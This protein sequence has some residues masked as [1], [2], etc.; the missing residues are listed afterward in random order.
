M[1][2]TMFAAVSAIALMGASAANA[3]PVIYNLTLTET[4]GNMGNGSGILKI[5]DANFSKV[6]VETFGYSFFNSDKLLDLS[7]TIGSQTFG[8]TTLGLETVKFT[9]GVLTD[10]N[11]DNGGFF[12]SFDTT[13]MT[14]DY[15]T[16]LG[17]GGTSKGIIS[18]TPVNAPVPEPATWAMM[19]GGF[20]AIG[21]AMRYRR[22]KTTVSFA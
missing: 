12:V 14:Y 10:V 3:A 8:K 15:S 17:L 13:R 1:T 9:N 4:S 21:G 7:F 2:K 19:I 20:G 16:F 22:R 6:G 11:Y 5:D 18:I